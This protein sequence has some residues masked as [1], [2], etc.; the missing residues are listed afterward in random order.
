MLTS[1]PSHLDRPQHWY[2]KFDALPCDYALT[3][4]LKE[5]RKLRDI[6]QINWLICHGNTR[7]TDSG[8]A[9]Q[10]DKKYPM[11]VIKVSDFLN[12][13]T[14]PTH[15]DLKQ[16]GKLHMHERHFFTIFVSHQCLACNQIILEHILLNAICSFNP[17]AVLTYHQ[18]GWVKNIL[19]LSERRSWS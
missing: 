4:S 6:T 17:M 10:L 13:S 14:F 5:G 11:W 15:Q 3:T 8:K 19:T 9:P 7:L 16:D 1:H 18:G 12:L 2:R